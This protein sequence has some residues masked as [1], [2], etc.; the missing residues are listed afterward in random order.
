M[1]SF[2]MGIVVAPGYEL[3]RSIV[4]L[5]VCGI[6]CAISVAGRR[7][8]ML[9]YIPVTL[10]I[11]PTVEALS[12]EIFS[13]LFCAEVLFWLF[14][15]MY[16]SSYSLKKVRKMVTEISIKNAIDTLRTGILFYESDGNIILCNESM[17]TLMTVLT[18]RVRRNGRYFA[19][20]MMDGPYPENCTRTSFEG[21]TVCL[22][23]DST[24]WMFSENEIDIKGKRYIQLTASD[25]TE[26]WRMTEALR[27]SRASL[28]R[29]SEDLKFTIEN[30]QTL[31]REKELQRAKMRAH[32]ILGQRLSILLTMIHKGTFTE[33]ARFCRISHGLLDE[34]QSAPD[35]PQPKED[36]DDLCQI[37]TSIGV[38]IQF[39]GVL[40]SDA[41]R[42]GI[43]VEII[44]ESVANA[45]R[46][47]FA[48]QIF[49]RAGQEGEV[50][51]LE[52][53]NNGHTSSQTV[54][55]GG[56]IGGMRKKIEPHSGLLRI[57]PH[58]QFALKV[59]L[60]GGEEY[61]QSSDS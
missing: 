8:S 61:D 6:S 26:Q 34:L 2:A 38:E 21:Q 7:P 49:V 56:G 59:E 19:R 55:E 33:D 43:F 31:C 22:L 50:D 18:G 1:Q 30:L 52:I 47:G 42:A 9:L 57:N 45:V 11:F 53:S 13:W 23:P 20:R 29:K 5:S 32:D 41:E 10:L 25:M 27:R 48:S 46:H 16:M 4:C 39:D 3:L 58:P 40:P 54:I 35:T 14:R 44:R 17:Q 24:A 28:Q 51:F 12:G 60:P 36:L 15:A 37:F